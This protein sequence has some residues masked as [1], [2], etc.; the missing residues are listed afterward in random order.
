MRPAAHLRIVDRVAQSNT[1]HIATLYNKFAPPLGDR[2]CHACV[3]KAAYDKPGVCLRRRSE[4]LCLRPITGLFNMAMPAIYQHRRTPGQT[5]RQPWRIEPSTRHGD[6][7]AVAGCALSNSQLRVKSAARLSMNGPS[8][9]DRK[10]RQVSTYLFIAGMFRGECHLPLRPRHW[11]QH[12]DV[13]WVAR[14]CQGAIA[15]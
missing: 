3:T 10:S 12:G 5:K 13:S 2:A 6:A 4:H 14:A 11:D 9:R 8:L 15:F 1:Y 7:P